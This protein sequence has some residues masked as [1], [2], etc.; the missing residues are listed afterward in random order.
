MDG[1]E[2]EMLSEARARLANTQE[3]KAKHKARERQLEE[4][5]RLAALQKKRELKAAGIIMQH[6][7]KK[8]G[9]DAPG[10][11]NTTE[12]QAKSYSAPVGQSLCRLETERKPQ[13]EEVEAKKRQ[14][15]GK[16]GAN[17]PHST[18]SIAARDAQIQKLEEAEQVS[19]RRSLMLPE[20]QLGEAELEEIVKI[21]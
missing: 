4:A 19:K 11:Y 13:E 16:V 7:T 14:K 2:E 1:D 3:K 17:E 18:E 6:K 21:R 5:R 9:R 15:Q 12:E 20:A 8:K 10:F